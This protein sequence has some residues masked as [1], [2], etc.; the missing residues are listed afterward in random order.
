VDR[1]ADSAVTLRGTGLIHAEYAMEEQHWSTLIV[2][3]WRDADGL[4]VR[5]M[6]TDARGH[7]RSVAVEA[8]VASAASRF[9]EWLATV[10]AYPRETGS[11]L[12]PPSSTRA[13][14][15]HDD[16]GSAAVETAGP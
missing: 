7:L 3:L 5:F 6:A 9:Q 12:R 4:K 2:R 10:S 8:S 1:R 11:R 14:T 15:P 13:E 16:D